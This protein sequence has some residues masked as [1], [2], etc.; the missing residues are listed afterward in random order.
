MAP[1]ELLIAHRTDEAQD[2]TWL[3]VCSHPQCRWHEA[4]STRVSAELNADYHRFAY[5][6]QG[7]RLS[8]VAVPQPAPPGARYVVG[9]LQGPAV[10]VGHHH[11]Q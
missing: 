3:A 10:P 8:I 2:W 11:L 4:A 7:H 9:N 6:G 1:P 5:S